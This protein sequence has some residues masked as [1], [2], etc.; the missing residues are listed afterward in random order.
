MEKVS[1]NSE[2]F[3]FHIRLQMIAQHLLYLLGE[4]VL[5]L[6]TIPE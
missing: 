1:I 6:M 2:Y 3:D 5:G 4:F